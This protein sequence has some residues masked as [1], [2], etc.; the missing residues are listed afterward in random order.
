M[1]CNGLHNKTTIPPCFK[2]YIDKACAANAGNKS[3]AQYHYESGGLIG[4][5]PDFGKGFSMDA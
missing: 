1:H 4:P 3:Y 5:K 2:E